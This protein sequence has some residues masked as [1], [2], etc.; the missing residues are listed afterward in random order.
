MITK[1][2]TVAIKIL[3][4]IDKSLGRIATALEQ[5]NE[6]NVNHEKDESVEKEVRN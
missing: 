2:V 5:Q 1:E 3:G 4:S 6:G